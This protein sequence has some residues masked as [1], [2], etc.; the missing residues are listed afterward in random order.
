MVLENGKPKYIVERKGAIAAWY[1]ETL[2]QTTIISL[3]T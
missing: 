3:V 1:G 2:D